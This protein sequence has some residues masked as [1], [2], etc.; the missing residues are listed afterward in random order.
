M[1]VDNFVSNRLKNYIWYISVTTRPPQVRIPGYAP[2][3]VHNPIISPPHPIR[4]N[5]K[6]KTL[7]LVSSATLISSL[8]KKKKKILHYNKNVYNRNSILSLI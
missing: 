7:I 3:C 6:N 2:D 8:K 5:N 1:K 4:I